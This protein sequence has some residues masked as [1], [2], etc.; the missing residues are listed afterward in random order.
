MDTNWLTDENR[1]HN[2]QGET[3]K[4][5]MDKITLNFIY[6]N[7][8]NYINKVLTEDYD[9]SPTDMSG[10]R[11]PLDN[12]LKVI[13]THKMR[14]PTSHYRLANIKSYIVDLDATDI[15]SYA[16]CTDSSSDKF[17]REEIPT[18][19]IVVPECLFVFHNINA[20]YFVYQEVETEAQTPIMKSILKS[21]IK[22]TH[23]EPGSKMTKKVRIND[24]KS[25]ENKP[26]VRRRKETR[27][28]GLR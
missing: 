4:E 21:E 1:L 12:L 24:K 20:I 15:Q 8:G 10:S 5:R 27:K 17:F 28:R 26:T 11:I 18:R 19:D 22:Q 16:D 13:Q 25:R 14:T 2:L 9:F 6:I 3:Q 23:R 7:C